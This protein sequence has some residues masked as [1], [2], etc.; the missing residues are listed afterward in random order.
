MQLTVDILMSYCHVVCCGCLH[1][2]MRLGLMYKNDHLDFSLRTNNEKESHF[3]KEKY[4]FQEF[5]IVDTLY[6]I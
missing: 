3:W 1:R 6:I 5:Y 4:S 2:Y